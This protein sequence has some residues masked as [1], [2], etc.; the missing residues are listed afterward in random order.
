MI[1]IAPY[2]AV[3]RNGKKNPKNYPIEYWKKLIELLSNEEIIQIGVNG[4]EKLVSDCRLGLHM[5][6]IKKLIDKCELFVCVDTFLQHMAHFYGKTGVVIFSQSDP[7]IF[8]YPEN[9]NLLK[10]ERHL[11]EKQFWMWEQCSYKGNSFINPQIV[12]E[13]VQ[14]LKNLVNS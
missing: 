11:R 8:G 3:M 12:Y 10:D 2:S 4:D 1:L 5:S 14:K 13:S 7:K 9:I 6:E